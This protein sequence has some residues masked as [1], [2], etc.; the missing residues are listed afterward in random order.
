MEFSQLFGLVNTTMPYRNTLT[1][2]RGN[3]TSHG[4]TMYHGN[5]TSRE[6]TTSRLL[7]I[8]ISTSKFDI[9]YCVLTQVAM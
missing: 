5:V 4:S 6:S 2:S 3:G 7:E 8:K 9:K 1:L